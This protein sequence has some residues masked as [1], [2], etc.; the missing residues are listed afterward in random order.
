MLACYSALAAFASSIAGPLWTDKRRAGG[1]RALPQSGFGDGAD[2]LDTL[3]LATRDSAPGF[4][5]FPRAGRM[6]DGPTRSWER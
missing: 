4:A 3:G 5:P 1:S 2:V 6:A